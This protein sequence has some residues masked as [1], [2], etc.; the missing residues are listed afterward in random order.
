MQRRHLATRVKGV[1]LTYRFKLGRN[2]PDLHSVYI[3][4]GLMQRKINRKKVDALRMRTRPFLRSVTMIS[5]PPDPNMLHESR[6]Y[7]SPDRKFAMI[8]RGYHGDFLS[9]KVP[10][11]T[12]RRRFA[13]VARSFAERN[14]LQRPT[15]RMVLHPDRVASSGLL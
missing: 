13:F 5:T 10:A 9:P 4:E 12:R 7:R 8:T 1:F 15:W 11:C 6:T 14:R 2:R 3:L